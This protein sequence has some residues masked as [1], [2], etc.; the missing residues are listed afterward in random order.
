VYFISNRILAL[1]DRTIVFQGTPAELEDFDHP[2]REEVIHSLEGLQEELT[3]LYS[4]RRFKVLYHSQL[5]RRALGETYC[6]A[7]FTLQSL[8]DIVAG[9]GH[10][11]AQEAI[12]SM[13]A[14]IDKHLGSVGGFSTR[15]RINEFV[16]ML[17]YSELGECEGL[18]RDF[19]QDFQEQGVGC[20]WAG[21][22]KQAVSGQCIEFAV[23]AGF[24]QGQPF[25]DMDAIIESAAKHQ[26]EIGRFRCPE[27][28]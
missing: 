9:L 16:A 15:R 26:K 1:Y 8:D 17:P 6:V 19:I 22:R 28:E 25:A 24:A 18:L 23:L 10:E 3:G 20:I 27:K 4:R 7:V 21:A 13:G 12:R 5:R 14:Y 11:A 2:F